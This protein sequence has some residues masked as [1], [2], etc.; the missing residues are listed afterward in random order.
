MNEL[1]PPLENLKAPANEV[2]P[3]EPAPVEE[4]GN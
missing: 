1:N 4:N 3:A 2:P